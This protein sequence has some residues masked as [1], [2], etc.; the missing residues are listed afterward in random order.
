METDYRAMRM[1]EESLHEVNR[2][3]S[4]VAF[5]KEAS[6][7]WE[8]DLATHTYLAERYAVDRTVRIEHP[9]PHRGSLDLAAT[10]TAHFD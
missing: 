3:T 7:P 6:C 1:V 4:V 5:A 10:E 8:A 2:V 9:L